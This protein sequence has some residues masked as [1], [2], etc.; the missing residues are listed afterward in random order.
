MGNPLVTPRDLSPQAGRGK[1][2]S[3]GIVAQTPQYRRW[4]VPYLKVIGEREQ[5][6]SRRP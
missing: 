3:P 5:P 1:V 4:G 6:L 2:L